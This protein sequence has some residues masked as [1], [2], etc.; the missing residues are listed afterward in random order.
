MA[1]LEELTRELNAL[2]ALVASKGTGDQDPSA[3]TVARIDHEIGNL[4]ELLT[5]KDGANDARLAAMD[6]AVSLLEKFPT[7]IDVAIGNLKEIFTEKLL[8]MVNVTAE[9]FIGVD[10]K[11]DELKER[12]KDGDTYR[13]TALD[14]ALKAAQTLVDKQQENTKESI[15]KTEDIFIK[16][17]EALTSVVN[18]LKDTVKEGIGRASVNDPQTAAALASMAGAIERLSTSSAKSSVTDPETA[19]RLMETE[20]KLASLQI[21]RADSGGEKRGIDNYGLWIFGAG[22]LVYAVVATVSIILNHHS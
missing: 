8:G 13:Q 19:R 17:I 5:A 7:A 4:R 20:I 12:L 2:K 16:Q 9:K 10:V 18:D 1:E 6:K 15:K 3:L 21:S 11:F 22:G 14:A